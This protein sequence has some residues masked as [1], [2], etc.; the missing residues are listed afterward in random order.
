MRTLVDLEDAQVKRLDRIAK[1]RE[2]SR[3]S[4]IRE[5]VEDYLGRHGSDGGDEAFG[6]WRGRGSD[7]LDF[8]EQARREW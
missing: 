3:A 1:R 2:R 6:L 7:G 8:Q 5:A 4:L